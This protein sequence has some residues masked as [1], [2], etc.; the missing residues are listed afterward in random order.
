MCFRVN[1]TDREFV[2]RVCNKVLEDFLTHLPSGRRA[3]MN[4]NQSLDFMAAGAVKILEAY[5]LAYFPTD[6]KRV[7]DGH[8]CEA[9]MMGRVAFE[10]KK[11]EIPPPVEPTVFPPPE[12]KTSTPKE[13]NP[14]EELPKPKKGGKIELCQ[15]PRRKYKPRQKKQH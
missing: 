10:K 9:K 14:V 13:E 11:K 3:E 12:K 4:E 7:L 6:I 8:L 1:D 15:T 2:C 5:G